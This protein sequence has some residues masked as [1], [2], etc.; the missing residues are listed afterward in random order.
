M[1]T[2]ILELVDGYHTIHQGCKGTLTSR[3]VAK[4]QNDKMQMTDALKN[5][6][7]KEV[8]MGV[9]R[10]RML[11]SLK[12]GVMRKRML[13]SLKMGVMRKGVK[14]SLKMGVMRKRL[15]K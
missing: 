7:L 9:M 4:L 12:M 2:F 11:E 6:R 13:E 15:K 5:L 8:K 10:K 3:E 1:C 14:K